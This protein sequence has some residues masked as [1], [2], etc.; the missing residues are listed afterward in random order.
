M[1]A[2]HRLPQSNLLFSSPRD[3]LELRKIEV[4]DGAELVQE[5]E[6]PSRLYANAKMLSRLNLFSN[7]NALSAGV[8]FRDPSLH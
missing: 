6:N 3:S 8:G 5:L 1:S 7:Q 4:I 2:L